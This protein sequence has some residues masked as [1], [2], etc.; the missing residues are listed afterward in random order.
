M[1]LPVTFVYLKYGIG[2]V[3]WEFLQVSEFMVEIFKVFR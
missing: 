2:D 1:L 3:I